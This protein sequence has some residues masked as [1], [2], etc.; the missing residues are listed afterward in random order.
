MARHYRKKTENGLKLKLLLL[1]LV[2]SIAVLVIT[3]YISVSTPVADPVISQN[4][5]VVATTERENSNVATMPC[6]PAV[7]DEKLQPALDIKTD[8]KKPAPPETP[9]EKKPLLAIIVDDGGNQMDLTKRVAAL[10]LPLTWAILPDTRHAVETARLADSKQI[11]CLVH[12]PMQ[13]LSD[14]DGSKEYVVGRGMT[15]EQIKANT[16][17]ALDL[18]PNAIGLNNHRGSLATSSGEIMEPVIAV[19]KERGLMFIDSRT[20]DK[21]VAYDVAVA[22]GV[23]SMKNR[24]FLDGS[25]EKSEIEKRFNEVTSLAEKRGSAI[26]ICHFR[27]TTVSY[28]ELLTLKRETLP[29]CLVT[30]P[31][32][33]S[34]LTKLTQ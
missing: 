23:P 21:S 8:D 17:K 5:A 14:Q 29:V 10:S 27:P 2:A 15:S 30:I 4:G 6:E 1:L 19:L 18:L 7:S 11:P 9:S 20:S 25:P 12:L 28:L 22:N 32:M 31:E 13:A 26:V 34:L 16:T 33:T 3:K 24:G